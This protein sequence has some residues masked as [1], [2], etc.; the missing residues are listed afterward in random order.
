MQRYVMGIS[1]RDNDDT[2]VL[3]LGYHISN[4]GLQSKKS[5]FDLPRIS[6]GICNVPPSALESAWSDFKEGFD[7]AKFVNMVLGIVRGA[8]TAAVSLYLYYANRVYDDATWRDVGAF[9]EAAGLPGNPD[10][11]YISGQFTF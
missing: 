3:I 2:G 10:P 1:L 8:P 6:R 9:Q 4:P 11:A 5:S 7:K